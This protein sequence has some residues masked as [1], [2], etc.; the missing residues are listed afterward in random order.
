MEERSDL[1]CE[2]AAP[3]ADSPMHG[4]CRHVMSLVITPDLGVS[5]SAEKEE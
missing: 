5:R 2:Y 1:T 3:A 4:W